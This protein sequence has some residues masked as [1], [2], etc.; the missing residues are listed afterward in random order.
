MTMSSSVETWP[1]RPPRTRPRGLLDGRVAPDRT[2]ETC[3]LV[4]DELR[5]DRQREEEDRTAR[6]VVR[7]RAFEAHE[8][9]EQPRDE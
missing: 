8:V 5:D 4:R 9:R 1:R 7:D 3:E 2:V 6:Q